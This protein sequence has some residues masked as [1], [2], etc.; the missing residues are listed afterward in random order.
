MNLVYCIEDDESIRE[1]ILY[2]LKNAG[3]E[4]VGF[5]SGQELDLGQV[6]DIF[7]LDIMLP[8]ED[9][10]QILQRIRKNPETSKTPVIMLTSKTSEFDKVRALDMG[11]DD[12]MDKPFGVMELISRIKAVLRRSSE[13]VQTG[14]ICI[15]GICLDQ[16]KHRVFSGQREI[17][18]TPKEFDLLHYLMKN[19]GIVL[20]RDKIMNQVWGFDFE[21]ETRTVDVHIRTLRM[22]LGENGHLVETVRGVG[23][24]FGGDS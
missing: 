4:A 12:Y 24:R 15:S 1:L 19:Q 18:L 23:Y 14:Q 21:G 7:L 9:G 13:S 3:F 8:G 22:K 20:S 6:P 16:N 17:T 11:A 5:E 10:Y 2:A